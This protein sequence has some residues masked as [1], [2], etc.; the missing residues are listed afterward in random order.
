VF[1]AQQ[2]EG[3]V[4]GRSRPVEEQ[5]RIRSIG[6][7]SFS[8][9]GRRGSDS[10]VGKQERSWFCGNNTTVSWSQE[11]EKQLARIKEELRTPHLMHH[12]VCSEREREKEKYLHLKKTNVEPISSL[13]SSHY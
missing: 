3:E 10:F 7:S 2:Q 5:C 11:L 9:R 8:G 4:A 6:W 13:H 12:S 1:C